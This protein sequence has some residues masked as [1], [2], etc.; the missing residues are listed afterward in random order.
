MGS[1]LPHWAHQWSIQTDAFHLSASA[2]CS[3]AV[4]DTGPKGAQCLLSFA[5][6]PYV[7][8]KA[9]DASATRRTELVGWLMRSVE[10]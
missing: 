5:Q 6:I 2:Q 8:F 9:R 7:L 3:C 10:K 1:E 4:S